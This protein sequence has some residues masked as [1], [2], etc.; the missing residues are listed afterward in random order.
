MGWII[1]LCVALLITVFLFTWVRFI[2]IYDGELSVILRFGIIR[3]R[4]Y[5]A[6]ERKINPK[7]YSRKKVAEL[8]KKQELK[9]LRKAEKKAEKKKKADAKKA[10]ESSGKT[11]VQPEEGKKKPKKNKIKSI[12]ELISLVRKLIF[13][14]FSK[15]FK[16]LRIDVARLNLTVATGDASS[17]AI[18]FGAVNAAV[19]SLC[20]LLSN[21]MHFNTNDNTEIS[22]NAD[23]L[24]E[25]SEA[26]IYISMRLRIW[27]LFSI[28][29]AAAIK[30]IKEKLI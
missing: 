17:T 13:I 25:K 15:F 7:R 19:G 11:D 3:K 30:F 16:Y 21:I 10:K 4:L 12:L 22:V 27:H 14:V 18:A 24:R 5:P 28:L 29:G 8:K 23:F 6:S 9:E 1:F 26:D 20:E 2:F